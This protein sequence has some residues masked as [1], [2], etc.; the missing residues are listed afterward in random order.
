MYIDDENN[1]GLIVYDYYNN[2]A[3]RY[4]GDT[5][6]IE[7]DVTFHIE[8]EDYTINTPIDGIA[9]TPD[10]SRLYWCPMTGYTIYSVDTA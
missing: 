6:K 2:K 7:D 8:G 1:G 4:Y 9:L 3:R 10:V 5:M